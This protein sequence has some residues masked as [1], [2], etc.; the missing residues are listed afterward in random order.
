MIDW[1]QRRFGELAKGTID[2]KVEREPQYFRGRNAE[3]YR[4]GEVVSSPPDV[5]RIQRVL[6]RL[7]GLRGGGCS[8]QLCAN[9]L[10]NV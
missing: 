9:T 1:S 3:D 8:F 4:A 6:S 10:T 5:W 2:K 7:Y